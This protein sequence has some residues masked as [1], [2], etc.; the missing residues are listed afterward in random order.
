MGLPSNSTVSLSS[1]YASAS[2]DI[3][4]SVELHHI[5]LEL[6]HQVGDEGEIF[7]ATRVAV[8]LGPDAHDVVGNAFID[9]VPVVRRDGVEG[10][11]RRCRPSAH[12]ITSRRRLRWSGEVLDLDSPARLPTASTTRGSRSYLAR[13]EELGFE[14]G[15]T[16]EQI[17]GHAPLI[18]P[19]ETAGLCRGVHHPAAPWCRSARSPRCM[20]R[21]NWRRPSPPS[22]GSATAGWTSA[23]AHGGNFRP[24]AAFGVEKATFISISPRALELMKAAWSDEPNGDVPRPL[25]RRRRLTDPAQARAA[26]AS[27]TLVRRQ[28]S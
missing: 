20:T 22:T 11:A 5:T 4:H 21:C 15:W 16:L 27:A 10:S 24:F 9:H 28:R 23:S 19:L 6:R 13:A 7:V 26:A 25:P 17:V 3:G 1:A 2:L 12:H 14:G 8:P 18:A